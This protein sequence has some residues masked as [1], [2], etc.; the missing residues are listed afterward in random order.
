M[1]PITT[2][3]LDT[4]N[5][6]PAGGVPVV[7][8]LE[9]NNEFKEI[10]AGITDSDGRVKNLLHDSHSLSAGIYRINFE[11]KK[12]FDK[13]GAKSFYPYAQIVFEIDEKQTN[14]HYHVPLLLSG[15]GYST[16]RGS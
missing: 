8:E 2:H 1:S 14:Q 10:G 13:L 4:A 11:T 15:Y 7:L 6:V 5:G 16:Y 9:V 12:Y 3:I